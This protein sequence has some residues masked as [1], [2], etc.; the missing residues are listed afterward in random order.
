MS[1]S[2][3]CPLLVRKEELEGKLWPI[4]KKKKPLWRCSTT[5]RSVPDVGRR[6]W[7]MIPVSENLNARFAKVSCLPKFN[8]WPPLP[9]RPGAV[10]TK[11][12][13]QVL[14]LTFVQK[15]SQLKPE[16]WLR[17]FVNM[18]P[19]KNVESRR[20]LQQKL[21]VMLPPLSWTLQR[22]LCWDG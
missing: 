6:G 3:L 17:P 22:W 11:G 21:P 20:N 19:G 12:L 9:T 16:A 14:G 10:F 2:S 7:E 4:K 15:Y 1:L 13:S 18:A 8:N 5:T